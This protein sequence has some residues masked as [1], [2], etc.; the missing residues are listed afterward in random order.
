M[1]KCITVLTVCYYVPSL[2]HV[3]SDKLYMF[4]VICRC[5]RYL[6]VHRISTTAIYSTSKPYVF[7]SKTCFIGLLSV[8]LSKYK[9]KD[10]CDNT[11]R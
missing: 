10:M 11:D 7:V 6:T 5:D 8:A 4:V 1:T 9:E 2:T 3:P